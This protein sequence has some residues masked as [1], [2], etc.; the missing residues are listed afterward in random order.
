MGSL[1]WFWALL[2]CPSLVCPWMN[3]WILV[4]V[5]DTDTDT[6][7]LTNTHTA[8]PNTEATPRGRSLSSDPLSILSRERNKNTN[9]LLAT[10]LSLGYFISI[11]RL[12]FYFR[13]TLPSYAT[14]VV[15]H[16]LLRYLPTLPF[17]QA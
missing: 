10:S 13:S 7:K 12:Y 16:Q 3:T 5:P 15:Y 11:S 17:L 9:K 6:S 2:S 8:S 14:D 4:P 1:S